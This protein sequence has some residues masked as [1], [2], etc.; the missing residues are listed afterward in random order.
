MAKKDYTL[1]LDTL[2]ELVATNRT[3]GQ[4]LVRKKQMTY[5]EALTYMKKPSKDWRFSIYQVG[6]C[7]MKDNT[8][9]KNE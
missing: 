7:S 4:D 5:A 1:P 2:V 3:N 6:F 9:N 8:K